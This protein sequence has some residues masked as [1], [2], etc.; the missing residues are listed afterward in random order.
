M[1][2]IN[3]AHVGGH[4]SPQFYGNEYFAFFICSLRWP[5]PFIAMDTF[6]VCP[7]LQSVHQ[8]VE[9]VSFYG[10]RVDRCIVNVLISHR[11]HLSTVENVYPL[12]SIDEPS[13]FAEGD[14]NILILISNIR[15][16]YNAFNLNC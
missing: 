10:D 2:I 5:I 8:S 6:F 3:A 4:I 14:A 12:L 7:K 1:W 13:V 15:H 9:D 16:P 11:L